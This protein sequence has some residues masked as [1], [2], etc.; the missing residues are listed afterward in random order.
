MDFRFSLSDYFVLFI[1]FFF[2]CA[3]ENSCARTEAVFTPYPGFKSHVKGKL[4][5]CSTVTPQPSQLRSFD[6][7]PVFVFPSILSNSTHKR[8]TKVF[9]ASTV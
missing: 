6:R 9:K 4:P 5:F 3:K 2:F 1:V 7:V 8:Q